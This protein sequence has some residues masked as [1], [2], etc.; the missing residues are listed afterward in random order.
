MGSQ[1][2]VLFFRIEGHPGRLA[3]YGF[4]TQNLIPE[5]YD[6]FE[7]AAFKVK[8]HRGGAARFVEAADENSE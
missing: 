3:T 4:R 6:V 1:V 2:I 5:G 7:G 8:V